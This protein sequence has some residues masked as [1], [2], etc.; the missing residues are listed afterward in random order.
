MGMNYTG[1]LGHLLW[2]VAH[3]VCCG[4]MYIYCFRYA[5]HDSNPS[6]SD[7]VSFGGWLVPAMK[8]YEGNKTSC[9]EY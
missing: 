9:G 5:H 7:F 3:A 1:G 6:F 2:C 8:Q 4:D